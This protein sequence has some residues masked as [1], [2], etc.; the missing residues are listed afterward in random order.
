[1]LTF[2]EWAFFLHFL[3]KKKFQMKKNPNEIP[4][5][6]NSRHQ[7]VDID[8]NLWHISA[9][10]MYFCFCALRPLGQLH[11]AVCERK[12]TESA[13]LGPG[14][15]FQQKLSACT[16]SCGGPFTR[17]QRESGRRGERH[18]SRG[19]DSSERWNCKLLHTSQKNQMNH[20]K[21]KC[22]C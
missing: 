18:Y 3:K 16:H 11:Q 1:M 19:R 4:I 12:E 8:P 10:P 20:K 15:N 22:I 7:H 14:V 2:N 6:T 17:E 9:R 13:C 5:F 21:T